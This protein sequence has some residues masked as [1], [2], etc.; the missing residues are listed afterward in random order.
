MANKSG[1]T[2]SFIPIKEVRDG[3]VILKDGSM[4]SV[5]MVS[6]LNFALKSKDEQEA[7]IYQF[8]NFLNSLDFSIQISVQSRSL[9]IKPYLAILEKQYTAQLNDLLR[10]QIREYI[11]FVHKFTEDSN[12]MT[13][14]FFVVISYTQAS[15]GGGKGLGKLLPGTKVKSEDTLFEEARSQLEQRTSIVQQGLTRCGLKS[16]QLNT[17]AVIELLYKLFNP[18]ENDAAIKL[19]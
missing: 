16:E 15:L 11:N 13:K 5:V 3:V 1:T 19:Q 17:E 9:D 10:I 6:S 2:Q 12:I 18:G 8:Q 4:K 7:I 14:T